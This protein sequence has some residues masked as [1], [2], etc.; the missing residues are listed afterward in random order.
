MKSKKKNNFK[1][2]SIILQNIPNFLTISRIII[3]LIVIYLIFNNSSLENI[4]IVFVIGALTDFLDGNLAR[5]FKWESEFGRKADMIADRFLWMGT[6]IAFI[7][8]FGI[9][10][11][12]NWLHGVQMLLIMT[13]EAI[14]IP[15]ALI[16]FFS[17]NALPQARYIAKITTFIQ[18]FALPSLIISVFYPEWTALSLSL[19][20][21]CFITGFISAMYY[22]ND[23]KLKEK[24]KNYKEN[25]RSLIL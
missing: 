3:S 18:G 20:L 15:F 2:D 19:A 6:A 17:G 1:K 14:S 7:V 23:V 22:M 9:E 12:L 24:F 16:A 4:I 10:G 13:R 25:W 11:E 5:R 21:M 8:V